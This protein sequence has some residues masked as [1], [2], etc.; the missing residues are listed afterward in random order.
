M[1]FGQLHS[2]GTRCAAQISCPLEGEGGHFDS[3][4]ELAVHTAQ[5]TGAPL[6]EIQ[7]VLDSGVSAKEAVSMAKDGYLG[8]SLVASTSKAA[9]V[10]EQKELKN[11]AKITVNLNP[12]FRNLGRI[13]K[14]FS[15]ELEARGFPVAEYES[16]GDGVYSFTVEAESDPND[17]SVLMAGTEAASA[18]QAK[19]GV[20]GEELDE[21]NEWMDIS[22]ALKTDSE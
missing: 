1:A 17:Y 11:P 12:N 2:T 3:V 13:E 7:D 9:P 22:G 8:R 15:E 10:A 14:K 6:E 4:N 21:Y 18:A 5:T 19:S 20:E 16:H